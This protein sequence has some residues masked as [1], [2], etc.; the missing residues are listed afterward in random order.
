MG[1]FFS[2]IS[3]ISFASGNTYYVAANGSD[4]NSG[5][6]SAPLK[7]I[8]KA[9]LLLKAGD[10]LLV[11]AGT[12]KEKV[13]LKNSGSSNSLITIK[14]YP[15]EKA[16]ISGT[17]SGGANL[18]IENKSYIRIEGLDITDNSG[19]DTPI[20]ISVKGFGTDIELVNNKVYNI[21]SNKN[22][23]GIAVY[24]T[25]S[26]TPITNLL[27]EG[28]EVF[29]CKL[30]QSESVVLNGN[31]TKF[32]VI[33]NKVH[34]NDNIAIDFIGYEGT[35]GSGETD[36][37]RDGVCSGNIIYNIS[38]IKN[39]TYNDY[40]AD[41]IYVDGGKDIIIEGNY[42]KNCDIGIEM[43]SEHKGKTTDNI[44]VR[45]NLI[46]D[47]TN[48]AALVFGG[49]GKSNGIAT[50]IKIYN[51]TVYNADTA[52]VIAN[53]DS[54]TNEVKNNIFNKSNIFIEGKEGKNIIQNNLTSDAKFVNPASGK[55]EL[56]SGSPAIDTGIS[57]NAG[58]LDYS[59][60]N[61]VINGTIDMGCLEYG[62][63]S[64]GPTPPE[65]SKPETSNPE[66]SKPEISKPDDSNFS[67]SKYYV[68]SKGNNKNSGSINRPFK[69]IEKGISVLKAGD[70][71]LVR[72]GTY[73]E[74]VNMKNSGSSSKGFI[75]VKNYPG[76]TV[77][78]KGTNK[79]GANLSITNKNY[80]RIEGL[81]I[82][83]NSGNNIPMGISVNGFGT[84]IQL[85]NNRI[86]NITSKT[87]AHAIGIYGSNAKKP[88]SNLLIE[89]NEVFNC[90]L[91]QS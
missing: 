9:V 37:A 44:T 87:N 41:G 60:K 88:I 77:I 5:S 36:R 25:N 61:R 89:G 76:E 3:P 74:K 29:N 80:I 8:Q 19:K 85:V 40:A 2:S 79:G 53:A 67:S 65:T 15:G 91:G 64:T 86:Y 57:V 59:L 66:I 83:D 68:S 27:I 84:D 82:A 50:N 71:L 42:V 45:N 54:S 39:P 22:A 34:D 46:L 30:G 58:N 49:E 20:G 10:T 16:I 70:T 12:Y 47:S 55:F 72:G 56:N 48:Y 18:L 38:S 78:L 24:G 23:H 7:T 90:K 81:N 73:K 13:T 14:N 11:R 43:A 31:V 17:G 6:I 62:S 51:N 69:T 35:A 1:I 63:E 75:T 52:L 33:N 32:K 28:N 4:N 21:V 26:K